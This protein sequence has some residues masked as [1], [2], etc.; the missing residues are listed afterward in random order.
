MPFLTLSSM[1]AERNLGIIQRQKARSC[2]YIS[3][4]DDI[5][6]QALSRL[7]V[8]NHVFLGSCTVHIGQESQSLSSA[9]F[10]RH[11]ALLKI[12]LLAKPT[13]RVAGTCQRHKIYSLPG[14]VPCLPPSRL[15]SL[16]L[17]VDQSTQLTVVTAL[18]EH[19][20]A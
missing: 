20:R 10:Q 4:R 1:K 13:N 6:H 12:A 14:T 3:P 19:P 15:S 5:S 8:A 17:G 7:P 18:A 2:C 11:T 16:D 9:P